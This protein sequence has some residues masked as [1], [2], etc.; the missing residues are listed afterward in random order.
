MLSR[1]LRPASFAE[2]FCNCKISQWCSLHS[3]IAN[4]EFRAGDDYASLSLVEALSIRAVG[5]PCNSSLTPRL[6]QRNGFTSPPQRH[7]TPLSS[8]GNALPLSQA[9]GSLCSLACLH[10]LSTHL[11]RAELDRDFIYPTLNARAGHEAAS[12]QHQ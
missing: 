4:F 2:K 5:H 1:R 11:Q 12:R 7:L 6:R 8:T 9:Q 3:V 10:S